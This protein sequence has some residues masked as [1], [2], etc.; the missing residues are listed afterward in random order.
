[1]VVVR[2]GER[3]RSARMSIFPTRILLATDGSEEAELALTTAVDL[4]ISTGSELHV[5]TVGLEVEARETLDGQTSKVEEAGGVVAE[6]HLVTGRRPEEEIVALS[7][8]VGAGLIVVGSRGMGGVRRALMGSTSDWVVRNA[9]CPVLVVRGDGDARLRPE[10][11]EGKS[12][13]WKRL[14]GPLPSGREQKVLEYVVY[15]INDGANLREVLGEE[16]VRRLASPREIE[17][18]LENPKLVEAARR[19]MGED[20]SSGKLDP[21]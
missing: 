9:R 18:I 7:E 11:T 17:Q 1:M 12:S 8:R 16:Y 14:F 21:G 13:F 5:T 19:A 20:F 2:Q 10:G 3:D 15:R 4:A 6:A